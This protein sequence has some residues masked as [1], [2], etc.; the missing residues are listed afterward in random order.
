MIEYIKENIS[1]LKDI[2]TLLFAGTG[3]ILAIFTYRRARATVLQPI[4]TEVI[5]KQ[6]EIL[7]RFLQIIKNY[8]YSFEKGLDYINLVQTNV[9]MTLTDYGFVFK[10]H[11][12]LSEKIQ[13]DIVGWLPCGKSNILK[14]IEIIGTFKDNIEESNIYNYSLEKY[15]N[16]KKQEIDIDK[17]Y[18]TK[19]HTEFISLIKEFKNDPFM[20][21]IIQKLLT[22]LINDINSNLT[23]ILKSELEVFMLD[24]SKVYFETNKAP[25]FDPIGI[26]NNYNHSRVHHRPILE[27]I[28]N[29]IRKYLRIDEKW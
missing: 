3:T 11:K 15:N 1:W 4:R 29:E 5:K 17:I 6:S 19:Q 23:I 8:N 27:L 25:I 26:Y 24:F 28:K 7:S 18:L 21:T 16:L 10:E 12:E 13:N 20:P 14:D 9:I 2:F 22:E